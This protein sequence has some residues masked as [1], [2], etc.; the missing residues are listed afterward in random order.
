M[1]RVLEKDG[2]AGI[3][4]FSGSMRKERR[5]RPKMVLQLNRSIYGVPDAGQSFAMFMQSLHLKRCGMVQPEM[6]PCI[7]Y[8][9]MQSD[10]GND[11]SDE[12]V[13]KEFL[14]A[15]TWVDDVRY[16]GTEKLVK[17]YEETIQ[18]HCKCTFEGESKEFVSIEISHQVEAKILEIK[19][20]EYW[21]KAV[22]RFKQYFG[23]DGPKVR[24]VS[25]S[26][27]DEKLLVEPTNEEI[28]AAQH[29]PY[30]SLLGVVQYPSC[31]T[32]VE[33]KYAMS[34]LSRWRTKWGTNHFAVLLKSLE[35]GYASREM[36]LRY[37][38]NSG[39]KGRS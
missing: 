7:Y 32:K 8:K 24:L 16:F 34:V 2:I 31:Y 23:K 19:Q 12:P 18:R 10:K 17:E 6:D 36:G 15:I 37:N 30:P 5:I 27:A 26:P 38:G 11:S 1:L 33:M 22:E 39:G 25:L 35:Y 3:K 14:L 13:L 20:V 9:M 28:A 21:V 4:R 29:L